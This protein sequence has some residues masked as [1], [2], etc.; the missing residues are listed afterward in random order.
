V[1]T[2][3]IRK[4]NANVVDALTDPT[5]RQRVSR[6][7]AMAALATSIPFDRFIST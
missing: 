3:V 6:A 2:D 1:P 5:M 7:T 4:L